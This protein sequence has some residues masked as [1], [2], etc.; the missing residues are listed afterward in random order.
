MLKRLVTSMTMSVRKIALRAVL[1]GALVL[2][3]WSLRALPRYLAGRD[4]A[5]QVDQVTA[6]HD[7]PRSKAEV[8]TGSEVPDPRVQVGEVFNALRLLQDPELKV[9]VV[10]L[11]MIR[12]VTIDGEGRT[13]IKLLLTSPSC[14]YR[15][16]LIQGIQSMATAARPGHAVVVELDRSRAWSESDLSE[17]GRRQ[18]LGGQR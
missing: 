2:M 12:D 3:A 16:V 13:Y 8:L 9:S 4:L 1:V 17:E 7:Q 11:G 6:T 14:P 15:E 18:L 5:L 10:D